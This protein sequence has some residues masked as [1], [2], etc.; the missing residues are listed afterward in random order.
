M[1]ETSCS[2]RENLKTIFETETSQLKK[3]SCSISLVTYSDWCDN[4]LHYLN[5]LFWFKKEKH[6]FLYF[7]SFYFQKEYTTKIIRSWYY[8]Y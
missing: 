4:H 8:D 2:E 1:K 7:Y 3:L 5:E 6:L